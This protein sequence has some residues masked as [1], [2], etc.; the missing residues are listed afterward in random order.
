MKLLFSIVLLIGCVID[1]Y[2]TN[3]TLLIGIGK[4]PTSKTE[5]K[6]I[7]GDADV[8]LLALN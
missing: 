3:R 6:Q 4:Y 7:H 2:A 1:N 5:W 8:K